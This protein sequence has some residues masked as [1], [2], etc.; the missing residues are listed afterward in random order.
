[1][2]KLWNKNLSNV[3]KKL[4]RLFHC[5]VW[6]KRW[7]RNHSL[8]NCVQ[9]NVGFDLQKWREWMKKIIICKTTHTHLCSFEV[10]LQCL[11]NGYV[12]VWGGGGLGWKAQGHKWTKRTKSFFMQTDHLCIRVT[13]N[14]LHTFAVTT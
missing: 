6:W 9:S 12:C 2:A 11:Y 13:I 14:R 10:S 4:F 1:M 7:F 8:E 3:R 5:Q